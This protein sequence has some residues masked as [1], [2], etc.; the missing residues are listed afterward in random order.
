MKTFTLITNKSIDRYPS[1]INA[2]IEQSFPA[3]AENV[4][5][6]E[7]FAFG[8]KKAAGRKPTAFDEIPF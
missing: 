7:S 6:Q 4:F 1:S 3:V 5:A 2:G 8:R